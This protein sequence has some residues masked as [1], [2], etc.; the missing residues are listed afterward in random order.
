MISGKAHLNPIPLISAK[1]TNSVLVAD[2]AWKVGR[3]GGLRR[4]AAFY[5]VGGRSQY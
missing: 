3:L 1:V 4:P 2:Q 5:N